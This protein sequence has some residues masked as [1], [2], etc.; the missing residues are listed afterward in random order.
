MKRLSTKRLLTYALL[1]AM[2]AA[3]GLMA[4][5]S[6]DQSQTTQPQPGASTELS[7]ELTVAGSTSVQPFSEVLAEEFMAKNPKVKVNVQGGGSTQ[8]VEAAINGAA[9]IGAISR[10]LKSDEKAKGLVENK[11]ALDGIAIVV[12]PANSISGLKAEDVRNIY[13]G[14]I[15]NW[16]QLGGKDEAITVVSREEGSG[17]L[18]GFVNLVMN[19]ESVTKK[20][21][22]QNS[23]GAVATTVAGDPKAIGFISLSKVDS[24]VKALAIDG[25]QPTTENIKKDAYKLYRPFYYITKGESHGLAKAFIDFVLSP[26]GQKLMVKEG[27]ISIN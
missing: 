9:G 25:Q 24:K 1:G 23:T 14:N 12:N 7:G 2:L 20:A 4:G 16:K 6:K 3:A 18:D 17:T 22:I 10:D 8:G 26:D 21:I 15:T 27:A 5:C 11:I 19:K 13:L